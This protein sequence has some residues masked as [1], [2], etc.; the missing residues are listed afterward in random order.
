MGM[1]STPTFR[2]LLL[3]RLLKNARERAG[4]QQD[5]AAR[6]IGRSPSKI[7]RLEDAQVGIGPGEAKVLL[8]AYGVNDP[9]VIDMVTDLAKTSHQRG[10]W[11][12]SR[13]VYPE[14]FRLLVELERQARWQRQYST[15]I[16]PGLLQTSAYAH[17]LAE[18]GARATGPAVDIVETRMERQQVLLG[19]DPAEARFVLSESALRRMYGGNKVMHEQMI[20]LAN[21][22]LRDNIQIQVLPFNAMSGSGLSFDFRMLKVPAG[23]VPPLEFVYLEMYDDARYL[24]DNQSV[25]TYD[26]LW[27]HVTSSALGGEE[28][29]RFIRQVAEQ[30]E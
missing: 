18:R 4:V 21:M 11:A 29:R 8:D 1:A 3:A 9:E 2:L 7:S 15:E 17:C 10:K 22:S 30:Y 27:G 14:W 6:L 24:D 19:D 26:K 16:V 20:H 25:H 12:G 5:E 13:A 28:S 23:G